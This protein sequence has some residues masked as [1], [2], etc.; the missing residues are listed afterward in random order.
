MADAA[1]EEPIVMTLDSNGDILMGEQRVIITEIDE[2]LRLQVGATADTSLRIQADQDEGV[3]LLAQAVDEV[4][5]S[6]LLTFS[7]IIARDSYT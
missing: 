6:S 3:G 4:K 2:L 5:R 1:A 7:L